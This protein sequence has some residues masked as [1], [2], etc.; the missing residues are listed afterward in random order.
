MIENDM[1]EEEPDVVDLAKESPSYP[2]DSDDVVYE[3]RSS[4][5]L[6]RGLGENDLDEDEEDYESSARLLGMSFMNR[7]SNQRSAASSYT[8]QQH[9]GSCSKPSTKTTVVGVLILVLVASMIM[10]IYFV[11]GCTFS[12]NGCQKTNSTMNSIYP[13]STSGELFPWTELRLPPS[14]HPVHYN[15]SLHPNLTLMTFQGSVSILVEVLHET[16]NIVLHSSDMNITKATFEGKEVHVLEYKPWQQIAI[17]FPEDLKKGKYVL[18]V[19][20]TANLSNSYDGFYN[21][22][23]VDTN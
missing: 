18:N 20:Y 7:S 5:L 14:V 8:R 16:K 15:I 4:R 6:V 19:N 21:S 1:F 22:S 11:P 10:V 9:S 3:P 23:Y 2:I 12:R 17:K 13:I